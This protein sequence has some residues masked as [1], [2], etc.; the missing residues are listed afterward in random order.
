VRAGAQNP[1]PLLKEFGYKI[2]KSIWM[3]HILVKDRSAVPAKVG[4]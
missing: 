2:K 3:N 1:L 4:R